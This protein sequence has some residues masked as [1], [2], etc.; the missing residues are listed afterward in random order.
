MICQINTIKS[1]ILLL[2]FTC[3]S[4]YSINSHAGN[5][6]S[7]TEF[8]LNKY[9]CIAWIKGKIKKDQLNRV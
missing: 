6:K 2:I 8:V 5:K 4:L 9:D 3:L 1:L 7:S